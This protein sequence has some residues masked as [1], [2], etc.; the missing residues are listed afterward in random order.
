MEIAA[1]ALISFLTIVYVVAK[2]TPPPPSSG[3]PSGTAAVPPS[4]PPAVV[5]LT[6]AEIIESAAA[7]W[8]QDPALMKAIAQKESGNNPAAVNPSDPS[9]GLFQIQEFWL[10]YF[11]YRRDKQLLMDPVIASD[12]A[13]RIL[14]YFRLRVNPLT[15]DYFQFPAEVDIYNVGETKWARGVRNPAYR[16][17]VARLYRVFGGKG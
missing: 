9:Y 3:G 5:T 16:D 1:I 6:I 17:D 14:R 4:A 8:N 15:G 13:A 10:S 12:V 2:K 7:K 11:G